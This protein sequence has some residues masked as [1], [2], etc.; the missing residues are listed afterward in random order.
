MAQ[1]CIYYFYGQIRCELEK[2]GV[3]IE[4]N[5][6]LIASM[7]LNHNGVLVTNNLKEFQRVK[8]LKLESW[9]D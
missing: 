7:V 3:V 6:L 1:L 2:R 4:P 8:N 9:V 5:D